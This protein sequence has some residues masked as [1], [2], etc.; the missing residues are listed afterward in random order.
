MNI[1]VHRAG[2]VFTPHYTVL[3]NP[4]DPAEAARFRASGGGARALDWVLD[5]L[6]GIGP[7]EGRQTVRGLEEVLL[8]QGISPDLARDVAQRA[9][10]RGEVEHGATDTRLDLPMDVRDQAQDEAISLTSALE[11]GRVRVEDM[12]SGSDPPA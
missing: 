10:E 6:D 9:L 8:Q 2:T 7:G 11:R 5:G 4:P 12:I 1:N 3:V